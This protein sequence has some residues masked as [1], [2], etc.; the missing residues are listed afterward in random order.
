MYVTDIKKQTRHF[1]ELLWVTTEKEL[2]TRY[3]YTILGFLWIVFIPLLQMLVIGFI[4]TFF[5]K[6]QIPRYNYFLY[7]G[8]LIWNFFALSVAKAT[9]SMISERDLITRAKFPRIIIPLSI[10]FSNL[11]HFLLGLVLVIIALLPAGTLHPWSIVVVV[12]ATA[13]LILFTIGFSGWTTALNVRYRDINFLV[14][15][16]LM[17]WFYATPIVY[18]LYFIASP[19][20]WLWYFN[21]LTSVVE[22]YQWAL[23]GT[24]G[25]GWGLFMANVAEILGIGIMGIIFFNRKSK[26]FADWI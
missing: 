9:S 25:P 10:I 2:R 4:F 26:H 16:I 1:I 21:P 14:Q 12:F 18:P 23:V 11:T 13:L 17:L 15:A 22:I 8:L 7:I 20:Q 6:E 24:P 19:M 3:K 5:V